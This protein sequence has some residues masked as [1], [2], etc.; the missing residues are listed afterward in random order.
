L[1]ER[2]T[3]FLTLGVEHRFQAFEKSAE[4]KKFAVKRYLFGDAENCI[5]WSF[6]FCTLN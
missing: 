6:I 5:M 3:G 1:Y 2:E 4:E